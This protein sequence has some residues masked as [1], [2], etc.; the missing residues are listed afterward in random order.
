M[1]KGSDLRDR[2]HRNQL[3]FP[4]SPGR[5]TSTARAARMLGVSDTTIRMMIETG[6]LKGTKMRPHCAKSPYRILLSS[7]EAH[8]DLLR[9][10]LDLPA[11]KNSL[12]ANSASGTKSAQ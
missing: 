7:L 8:M 11:Q 6:E 3:L 10:E 9:S 2:Q 12:S 4:W 1:S 5:T